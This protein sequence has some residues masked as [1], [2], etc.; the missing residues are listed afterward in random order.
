MSAVNSN[1][2]FVASEEFFGNLEMFDKTT[3]DKI[4]NKIKEMISF[5][6]YRYEML[7]GKFKG[8]R[9]MR[10]GVKGIQSGVR[11][12]YTI[13]EECENNGYNFGCKHCSTKQEK[14]ITLFNVLPRSSVYDE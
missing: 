8:K 14:T 9:K 1:Y 3:Q 5:N 2:N 11:V 13:C 7:T 12:I 4:V 10:I 6:P